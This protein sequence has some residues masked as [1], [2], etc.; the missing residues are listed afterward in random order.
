MS[1]LADPVYLLLVTG[2]VGTLSI[3]LVERNVPAIVNA[4]AALG[5]AF[6]PTALGVALWIVPGPDAGAIVSL[7]VWTALAGLLH[8]WGMLGWYDTVWW[9]DHVTH[10]VSAGVVAVL[11]YGGLHAADP[12]TWLAVAG[13]PATATVAVVAVALT[14][15]LGLCWEFGELLAR[16]VG[17]RYDVEPVLE[18]YGVRD[19][20][21]DL[22]F[23]GVGAVAVVAVDPRL[24]GTVGAFDPGL[25]REVLVV[26]SVASTVGLVG[27]VAL[28]ASTTAGDGA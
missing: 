21:F 16:E 13:I 25:A 3:A 7:S 8:A 24:A 12:R 15:G 19:T 1:A 26:G 17:E 28:T 2:I 6:L 22:V 27:T 10:T 20:A 11:F 23:D 18:H 4:V 14:L 9:W 5:V